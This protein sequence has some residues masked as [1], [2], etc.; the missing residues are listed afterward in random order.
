MH[1]IYFISGLGADQRL[2]QEQLKEGIDLQV[3]PWKTPLKDES[4]ESYVQRMAAE[5]PVTTKP[6]IVGGVSFGGMIALEISK[7]LKTEKVII[8]SSIKNYKELPWHIRMWKYFP[9]YQIL[10]GNLIKK[11][12]LLARWVF[13]II[14]KE[15][16]SLFKE[17]I[18]DADPAFLK[19]AI[20][21]IVNWQNC[22]YPDNIV[23]LHGTHD[24]IFPIR[25]IQEPFIP[26]PGGTHVMILSSQ[27]QVNSILKNECKGRS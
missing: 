16:L 20:L 11:A 9:V 19:W 13:G 10:P 27:E 26:I 21:R 1:R 14:N 22:V 18:R 5:I 8:V 15:E 25:N 7:L 17:M 2:F 4:L 24:R 23:H 6:V 3:I 12:G